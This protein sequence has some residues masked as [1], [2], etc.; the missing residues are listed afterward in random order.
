MS[1]HYGDDF[2]QLSKY[3]RK[4]LG[5]KYLDWENQPDPF[6]T[7]PSAVQIALPKPS[8]PQI[9]FHSTVKNRKS[10]RNYN[11][12]PLSLEKLSYLLWA[13]SGIRTIAQGF[14]FRTV[15]SAGALYPIETYLLINNVKSLKE[16]IYHFNVIDFSLETL[17]LG[18]FADEISSAALGQRMC[19]DAQVVFIWTAIFERSKW[20]YGERAYR[21]IY[22]DAGHIAQ[23]LAL[24]AV[25][26]DLGTCQIGALFDDEINSILEIDGESESVIYM[27]TVGI[28]DRN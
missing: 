21:Y 16:G 7:Y 22:L 19:A 1:S 18:F 14:A 10:I 28:P 11:N 20:K 26:L 6:K 9:D 27:S 12:D 3:S 25:A 13:T 8:A 4:T 5:G 24:A 2:Q 23:N 15:P 17:R